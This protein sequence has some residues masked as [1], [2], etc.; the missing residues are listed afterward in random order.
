MG[1]TDFGRSEDAASSDGAPNYC[2]PPPQ[3]F[4]L[5]QMPASDTLPWTL[6]KSKSMDLLLKYMLSQRY[7]FLF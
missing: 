3:I 2:A 1:E 4:R 6:T 5:W 7:D